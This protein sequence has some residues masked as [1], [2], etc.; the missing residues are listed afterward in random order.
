MPHL[1]LIRAGVGRSERNQE[2]ETEEVS[3]AHMCPVSESTSKSA[4]I[5]TVGRPGEA[6]GDTV[7]SGCCLYHW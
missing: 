6:G 7:D 5:L 4:V 3:W 1:R 2:T